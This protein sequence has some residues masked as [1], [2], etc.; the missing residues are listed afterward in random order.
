MEGTS[1]NISPYIGDTVDGCQILHH[2]RDGW[3]ML[4]PYK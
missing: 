4:K 2:R 3:N 1:Q